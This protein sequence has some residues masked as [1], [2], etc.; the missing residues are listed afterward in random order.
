MKTS[1][2]GCQKNNE[3]VNQISKR[4]AQMPR[5]GAVKLPKGHDRPFLRQQKG[6]ES[7]ENHTKEIQPVGKK[8]KTEKK[9]SAPGGRSETKPLCKKKKHPHNRQPRPQ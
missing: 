1:K 7:S 8:L 9:P 5:P 3:G 6:R 2:G 4:K